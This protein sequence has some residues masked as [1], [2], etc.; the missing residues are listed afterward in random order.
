MDKQTSKE[1]YKFIRIR[2]TEIIRDGNTAKFYDKSE[3]VSKK[4]G[5][6]RQ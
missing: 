1:S 4:Q 5:R 6:Q 3:T 2:N